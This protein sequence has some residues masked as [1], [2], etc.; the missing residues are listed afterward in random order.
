MMLVKKDGLGLQNPVASADKKFSRSRR[1]STELIQAGMGEIVFS[2]ADRFQILKEERCDGQKS[3]D[4][5]NDEKIGGLVNNLKSP[6][7]R[8]ILHAKHPGSWLT[9][10]GT[11]VISILLV[12]TEFHDLLCARYDV[13]PHNLKNATVALSPSPYITELAAATE[14]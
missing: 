14:D 8:L 2:T 4:D 10:W 5:A 12:A 1:A 9:V 3:W 13:T 6:D 7:T 11:R